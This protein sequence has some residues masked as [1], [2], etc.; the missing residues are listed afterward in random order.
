MI[1]LQTFIQRN[2]RRLIASAIIIFSLLAASILTSVSNTSH[3]VWGAKNSIAPGTPIKSS[4]LQ[5][6]SVSL[7]NQNSHYFS[8]KAKLIGSYLTKPI[9]SG[10]LIPT[11]AISK[12]TPDNVMKEVPI[13]IAR[14]DMPS[15]LSSGD[16]V[17][18]YS[19]PTKDPKATP[20]LIL[21]R[22]RVALVDS[23]S[24]NLGGGV[25]VLFDLNIKLVLQVMDS[26]Q[27]GRIVVVRNA[28]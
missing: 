19:I 26:I 15:D 13:S 24:R 28:L 12:N 14:G 9:S 17:D 10:E 1:D 4:D 5:V 22:A 2:S 16:T 25:D 18:L 27:R 21:S 6:F 7:G 23:Q 8:D 20:T 11:S 3:G